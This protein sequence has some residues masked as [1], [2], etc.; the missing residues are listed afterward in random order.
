MTRFGDQIS[1][2]FTRVINNPYRHL[3][4][5][6]DRRRPAPLPKGAWI[7]VRRGDAS[8]KRIGESLESDTGNS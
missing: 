5:V 3:T 6:G 2:M 7:P 8:R 4:A 1:G